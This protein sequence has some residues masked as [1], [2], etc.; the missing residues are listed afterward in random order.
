[1]YIFQWHPRSVQTSQLTPMSSMAFPATKETRNLSPR[2][3]R[4]C[5]AVWQRTT[6]IIPFQDKFRNNYWINT[7]LLNKGKLNSF[8]KLFSCRIFF[9]YFAIQVKDKS[10]FVFINFFNDLR[11]PFIFHIPS[12]ILTTYHKKILWNVLVYLHLNHKSHQC[13][14]NF[15]KLFVWIFQFW[16]QYSQLGGHTSHQA[17][18]SSRH[19]RSSGPCWQKDQPT[20]RAQ[21]WQA[22]CSRN[23]SLLGGLGD[24]YL[25][26][27]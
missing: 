17:R 9:F 22:F 21:Y 10:H 8:I 25:F 3:S 20:A 18:L 19:H 11:R 1:M 16:Y 26:L 6:G 14:P 13:S 12:C 15:D 4:I 24:V 2:R 27:E 7:H 5:C 23:L